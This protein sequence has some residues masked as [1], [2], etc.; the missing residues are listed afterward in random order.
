MSEGSTHPGSAKQA[1]TATGEEARS[2]YFTPRRLGATAPHDCS[3][4]SVDY[5]ETSDSP[6]AGTLPDRIRRIE[7]PNLASQLKILMNA[8][9]G[10]RV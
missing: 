6:A 8:G 10:V 2:P 9:M 5:R 7:D 3:I 1:V 4:W